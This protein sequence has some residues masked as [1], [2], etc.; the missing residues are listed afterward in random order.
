MSTEDHVSRPPELLRLPGFALAHLGR[1]VRGAIRAAFVDH[2]LASQ[3]HFVLACL[4][5]YGTQSQRELA[6]RLAMDRSDLTKLVDKLEQAGEVRREPDPKDRRRY[7]LSITRSG[8][9]TLK[10]GIQIMDEATNEVLAG[11][12]TQERAALEQLVLRAL[13]G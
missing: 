2:G 7:Q 3:A 12:T 13:D 11:L 1:V 5:E 9:T 8:K 4:D 10:R 6:D